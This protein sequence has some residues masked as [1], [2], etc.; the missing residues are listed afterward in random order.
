MTRQKEDP[1]PG[2]LLIEDDG[3][4]RTLWFDRPPS[5]ALSPG[6]LRAV[7]DSARAAAGDGIRCLTLASRLPR[8]FSS[9]LDLDELFSVPEDKRLDILVLLVETHR[10]VAEFPG[11]SIAAISGRA[12]LGGWI[13][14]MGCDFRW[15]GEETGRFALSEIHLG[16]TPSEVLIRRLHAIGGHPSLIRELVLKGKTLKA[17]EGLRG[18]FVD[19]LVPDKLLNEAVS[20]EARRL[21]KLPSKAYASIKRDLAAIAGLAG[22]DVW[23]RSLAELKP[24][25]SGPEGREGFA[26][27]K[28]RRRARWE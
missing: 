6:M 1:G 13:L 15:M 24:L 18:G 23:K 4:V 16:I 11:P 19:R 25:F 21:A 9:G 8:Y 10:A 28:E 14:A 7:R 12:I 20:K 2:G 22:E 17:A 5:N 27:L 3:G 26:A